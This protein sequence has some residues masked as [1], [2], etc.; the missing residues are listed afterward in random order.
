MNLKEK[1]ILVK[2]PGC[3]KNFMFCV[4]KDMVVGKGDVVL[5]DTIRGESIAVCQTNPF[6]IHS[7]DAC[8]FGAYY[9]LKNVIQCAGYTIRNYICEK[10]KRDIKST[11]DSCFEDDL[12][13]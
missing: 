7:L 3:D 8:A 13:Y 5:V 6:E 2:H 10:C 4:P 11:I 9:P 12:P 1:V